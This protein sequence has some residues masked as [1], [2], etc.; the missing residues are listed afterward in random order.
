MENPDSVDVELFARSLLRKAW[1]L[2]S[3]E[4]LDLAKA[5]VRGSPWPHPEYWIETMAAEDLL[6]A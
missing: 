3:A 4:G 5:M 1:Y 2:V 6:A